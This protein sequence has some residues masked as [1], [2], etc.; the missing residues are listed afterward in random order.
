MVA[1]H[2]GCLG[3]WVGMVKSSHPYPTNIYIYVTM[4]TLRPSHVCYVSV[5]RLNVDDAPN[6]SVSYCKSVL[7]PCV[8]GVLFFSVVT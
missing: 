7:I 3:G 8:P 1:L 2:I 4:S 6:V 5:V